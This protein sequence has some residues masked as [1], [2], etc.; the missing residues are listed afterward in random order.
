[1]NTVRIKAACDD[2]MPTIQSVYNTLIYRDYT[3]NRWSILTNDETVECLN[4]EEAVEEA[5]KIKAASDL[6]RLNPTNKL[7]Y[8]L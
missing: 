7:K 8:I 5:K 3:T 2:S 4:Y 1:M 6:K